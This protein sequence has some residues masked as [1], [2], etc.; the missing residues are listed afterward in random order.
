MA[1]TMVRPE[2]EVNRDFIQNS[3]GNP[4]HKQARRGFADFQ[5]RK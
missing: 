5:T 2:Y 3:G 4:P 1:E